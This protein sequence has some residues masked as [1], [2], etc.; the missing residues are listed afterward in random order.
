[1]MTSIGIAILTMNQYVYYSFEKNCHVNSVK[2]DHIVAE[3]NQNTNSIKSFPY[4]KAEDEYKNW[5]I[6]NEEEIT[7]EE[8]KAQYRER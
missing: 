1:M 7:S 2:D 4:V 8:N 5:Y 3:Q 6:K